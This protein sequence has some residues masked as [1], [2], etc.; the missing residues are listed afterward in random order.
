MLVDGARGARARRPTLDEHGIVDGDAPPRSTRTRRRS[1]SSPTS[2]RLARVTRRRTSSR[3]S[4]ATTAA[5]SRCRATRAGARRR[6][7]SPE[8]ADHVGHELVTTDGTTLLGADDKA[9]VAE[10][11]AA[12]A[13]LVRAPG[14]PARPD[15]HRLHLRRGD[16]PRRRSLRPRRLRRRG[17]LHARRRRARAR[18][19][20]RRSPPTAAVHVRGRQHP[21][22]DAKGRLVNA[23]RLAAEFLDAAAAA[24]LSP[25]TTDGPR[26]LHAPVPDRGRRRGRR[27]AHHPARL[28]RRRSW[29]STASCS[30]T[31]APRSAAGEPRRRSR[32]RVDAA[33]PQ[34]GATCLDER[35]AGGRARARRR[36]AAPGLEPKRDSIRGGTD[37][38]RLTEMGLPTPNLFTGEHNFHSPLEWVCVARHG[39]GGRRRRAPRPALGRIGEG[40]PKAPSCYVRSRTSSESRVSFS[41]ASPSSAPPCPGPRESRRR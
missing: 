21:P 9:G 35:P 16:R 31:V 23:I 2:T 27:P 20:T 34:H 22:G 19:R 17:R 6:R 26:G 30:Q 36:S 15:P 24:T 39:R 41:F 29:P 32:S 4:S 28:R 1:A 33:V 38:S 3:R 11:M 10:I 18:S 40:R 25:E 13:Y 7:R 8:L 37:G 12:A 5:T 14:D